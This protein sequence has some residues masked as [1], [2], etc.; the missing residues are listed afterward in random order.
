MDVTG[1]ND[2][3]KVLDE[4]NGVYVTSIPGA[5]RWLDSS[6]S[7]ESLSLEDPVMLKGDKDRIVAQGQKEVGVEV[8]CYSRTENEMKV[9]DL[10]EVIG[11][12][13]IPEEEVGDENGLVIHAV[14]FEK[15]L[16][17]DVV[18]SPR[19]TVSSGIHS[20]SCSNFQSTLSKPK[21]SSFA[22]LQVFL[23]EILSLHNL[24]C[25]T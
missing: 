5:A 14:T 6:E 18:L 3:D 25:L 12:L 8:K 20:T 16:L 19:E 22:T 24:S 15:K 21:I 2:S 4:R 10:V 11:I 13:E 1:L 17:S 23:R 7:L 9:C